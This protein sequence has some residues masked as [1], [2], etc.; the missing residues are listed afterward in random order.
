M[1]NRTYQVLYKE[2]LTYSSIIGKNKTK[3]NFLPKNLENQETL[4]SNN[5]KSFRNRKNNFLQLI[6]DENFSSTN[7]LSFL[8]ESSNKTTN[9]NKRD[10]FFRK[11]NSI[12]S[13]K[14]NKANKL[15]KIYS[16]IIENRNELVNE[17]NINLFSFNN[18]DNIDYNYDYNNSALSKHLNKKLYLKNSDF[19]KI[20]AIQNKNSL[21]NSNILIDDK[22]PNNENDNHSLDQYLNDV[23]NENAS[24]DKNNSSKNEMSN[25]NN[26]NYSSIK[27]H[28]SKKN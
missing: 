12:S 5:S 6:N 28:S 7:G 9:K 14:L 19:N 10:L 1:I 4:S 13:K 17:N 26:N 3:T 25:Q 11:I 15:N 16:P 22:N 24:T 18:N 21:T 23:K 27:K 2:I 8:I 20:S